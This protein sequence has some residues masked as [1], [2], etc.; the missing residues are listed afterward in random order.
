MP[1]SV[2]LEKGAALVYRVFDIAE[3]IDLAA[4]ERLLGEKG[5]TSRLKLERA[6]RAFVIRNAPVTLSLGE[7]TL[8]LGKTRR[9]LSMV[10]RLWD[11]GILSVQF[12]L[13][14]PP[15]LDWTSL[16]AL[17]AEIEGDNEFDTVARS[18]VSELLVALGPALRLPHEWEGMEDYTIYFIE[19]F[20]GA[21]SPRALLDI[22]NVP[23]LILGEPTE[24]LSRPVRENILDSTLQYGEGDMAVIDWNSALVIEPG[25]SRDVPDVLEFAVT[26]LMEFRYYDDLLDR[27]L[28]TIYEA[29]ARRPRR[30][31]FMGPL[32]HISHEASSRFIEFSE[33]IERVENSL[34]VV[35]DFY[36]A[37]VFRAATRRFRLGE[38]E[39]S[40]TRKMNLL[41]RVTDLLQGEVNVQRSHWLEI[42]VIALIAFEIVSAILKIY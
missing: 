15:D 37:T 16:V 3:E 12:H 36:L 5:P 41:A 17:A 22:V 10:A 18:T 25:G 2:T 6:H 1:S 28:N 11:Y 20:S 32:P 8:R 34:K 42:I 33:F 35:G 29:M 31:L 13:P 38:W 27:R 24:R 7:T 21:D 14:L 19:K 26:H 9:T 39:A 40:I 30:R 23:A 4:V